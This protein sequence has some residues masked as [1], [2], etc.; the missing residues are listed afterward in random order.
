MDQT[1]ELQGIIQSV[2]KKTRVKKWSCFYPNCNK[3]SSMSHSQTKNTSLKNIAEQNNHVIQINLNVFPI[4]TTRGWSTIGID[5]A[6][7]FPGFCPYHDNE[8]FKQVD[9]LHMNNI[10]NKALAN[11]AFRTFALEMRKKEIMSDQ[12][13]RLLFHWNKFIDPNAAEHVHATMEGMKN[14]IKVTKPYY[15]KLFYQMIESAYYAPMIHKIFISRTNLGV[16]C[17]TFINP[18][19]IGEY[20]YN[21]PQPQISFNI[22]PRRDYSLIIFSSFEDTEHLMDD[23]INRYPRL[24]DI[25]FNFCEEVSLRISLYDTLSDKTLDIIDKAQ[26]PWGYWEFTSVPDIF[27]FVLSDDSLLSN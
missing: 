16:S 4:R 14:C 18:L 12:S 5:K 20:P 15:L 6:T 2:T 11:L 23:F 19:D 27:N 21:K 25:V 17:S 8:L 9:I 24:E 22:L 3:K 13:S 26:A 1:S 7:R 10:T